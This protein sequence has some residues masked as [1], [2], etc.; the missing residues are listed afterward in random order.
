MTDHNRAGDPL[1]PNRPYTTVYRR[2]LLRATAAGA[3]A[4]GA[5]GLLAACG[6]GLKGSGAST[7][8]TLKIGY[9]SPQTGALASFA[10]ADNFVVKQVTE[11]LRNGITAGG[12]TRK[13]EIVVKDTQ[14]SST[15]AAEMA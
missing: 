14:S 7:T 10:L 8:D 1:R 3:A 4:L 6:K 2:D 15:R 5:G 11:V 13:I 9:V 12:K